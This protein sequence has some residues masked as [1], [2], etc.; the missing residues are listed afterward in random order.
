MHSVRRETVPQQIEDINRPDA[1]DPYMSTAA[2]YSSIESSD[3][4]TP[5]MEQLRR[6][7][8]ASN[9]A[10]GSKLI[11]PPTSSTPIAHDSTS[12]ELS[13][14]ISRAPPGSASK[15]KS[16]NIP[17]SSTH[18]PQESAYEQY[19]PLDM[20]TPAHRLAAELVK[21]ENET[22]LAL[23][24]RENHINTLKNEL[25]DEKRK[26]SQLAEDLSVANER[27][28]TAEKGLD[29]SKD[30]IENLKK[31]LSGSQLQSQ[32]NATKQAAKLQKAQADLIKMGKKQKEIE[33][34]SQVCVL[35]HFEMHKIRYRINK[36]TLRKVYMKKVG[37]FQDNAKQFQAIIDGLE[38]ENQGLK[39]QTQRLS[40]YEKQARDILQSQGPAIGQKR[41][42]LVVPVT[43]KRK[44]DRV[45]EAID[46][47]SE[48]EVMKESQRSDAT[49]VVS[50]RKIISATTKAFRNVTR[51][52]RR[53]HNPTPTPPSHH[54]DSTC[55]FPMF[56]DPNL[57]SVVDDDDVFTESRTF[58]YTPDY[59]ECMMKLAAA[60]G[61]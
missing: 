51:V 37:E 8:T 21:C 25:Q 7:R 29:K 23:S 28:K 44:L 1:E 55:T 6:R 9:V 57:H 34:S 39:S 4:D 31:E 2:I 14:R 26:S 12:M 19:T 15:S 18:V 33:A 58:R 11:T 54:T 17:M 22:A 61:V 24:S 60:K 47:S 46:E 38:K 20:I 32:Q 30:C 52:F 13:S 45:V 35:N 10:Q 36:L 42:K 53:K 56:T 5:L 43:R 41:R 40:G 59:E 16:I 49:M 48:P 3:G 50:A 27:L